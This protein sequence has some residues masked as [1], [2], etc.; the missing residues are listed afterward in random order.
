MSSANGVSPGGGARSTAERKTPAHVLEEVRSLR[1]SEPRSPAL[2][3]GVFRPILPLATAREIGV[4]DVIAVSAF[5]IRRPNAPSE[6]RSGH[7]KPSR[8]RNANEAGW[9][10]TRAEI[11]PWWPQGSPSHGPVRPFP[12]RRASPSREACE[13]YVRARPCAREGGR[14]SSR[15]SRR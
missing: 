2:N 10:V 7:A 13:R 14:P 4:Y 9:R 12:F 3:C 8:P 11:R 15:T 6:G 1:R 5:I